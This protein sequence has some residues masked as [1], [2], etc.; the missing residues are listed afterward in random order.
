MF[1]FFV[2]I[3][4]SGIAGIIF[5]TPVTPKLN[6]ET[7]FIETT[8]TE[9]V[10]EDIENL[11]LQGYEFKV[12]FYI[13]VIIEKRKVHKTSF[14]RVLAFNENWTL[15]NKL[16]SKDDIQ[17]HF[18]LIKI[19]F[20]D[21]KISN[22]DN[23]VVF[24]KAKIVDDNLFEESTGLKTGILWENYIPRIKKEYRFTGKQFVE[25]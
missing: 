3:I 1:D 4:G 9:P 18:G 5:F 24:V 19:N 22:N 25:L 23:I 6:D 2:K 17:K 8:L 14:E 21:V 7:L 13:S 20:N 10:T 15:D 12:E 11:I 16:I